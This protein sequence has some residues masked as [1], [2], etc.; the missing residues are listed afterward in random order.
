MRDETLLNDQTLIQFSPCPFFI[1]F[2]LMQKGNAVWSIVIEPAHAAE[3]AHLA[4]A[5]AHA[6]EEAVER[7]RGAGARAAA[8]QRH[9]AVVDVDADEVLHVAAAAAAVAACRAGASGARAGSGAR[10]AGA[11]ASSGAAGATAAIVAARQALKN[12]APA[13]R[14]HLARAPRALAVNVRHGQMVPLLLLLAFCRREEVE[15]R[16]HGDDVAVMH[17]IF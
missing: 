9:D 11:N 10:A 4:A 12:D 17:T 15:R 2:S 7:A 1:L 16:N 8:G 3:V 5:P 13:H 6:L 14:H